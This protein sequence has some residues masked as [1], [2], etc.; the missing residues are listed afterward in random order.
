MHGVNRKLWFSAAK[1]AARI[2]DDII[3]NKKPMSED[4]IDSLQG[5][6][7]LAYYYAQHLSA[8][9]QVNKKN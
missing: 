2:K 1:T 3:F 8:L 9:L 7:N 5:T 6:E 4:N